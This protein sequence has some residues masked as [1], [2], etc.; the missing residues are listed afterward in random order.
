MLSS[1]KILKTTPYDFHKQINAIY[2]NFLQYAKKYAIF[3]QNTLLFHYVN[4]S[5]LICRVSKNIPIST[6]RILAIQLSTPEDMQRFRDVI[7]GIAKLA[8]SN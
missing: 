1:S 2:I 7:K 8:H 3:S 6:V 5:T 4:L